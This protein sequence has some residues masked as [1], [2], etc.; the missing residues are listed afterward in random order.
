VKEERTMSLA[1]G[2]EKQSAPNF[3]NNPEA[4]GRGLDE[5][6][7]QKKEQVTRTHTTPGGEC[8]GQKTPDY[9]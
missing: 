5:S 9:P 7:Q 4:K 6:I 3:A 8:S 2:L 1:D